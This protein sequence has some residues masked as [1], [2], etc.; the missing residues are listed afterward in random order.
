MNKKTH[1]INIQGPNILS[2]DLVNYP[3]MGA[4]DLIVA[5]KYCGICGTDLSYLSSGGL[6]GPQKEP[7]PLGHEMSGVVIEIGS[8]I[9]N[10]NIDDID[11]YYSNVIARSSKTMTD[12]RNEKLKLK[13]T[14][15]EG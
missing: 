9:K 4:N 14:T 8:N 10:I 13:N 15:N 3:N 2:L 6:M 12:C 1:Q 7:M 5:I 11:Y